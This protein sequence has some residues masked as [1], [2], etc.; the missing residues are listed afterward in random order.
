MATIVVRTQSVRG[1][2]TFTNET[3]YTQDKLQSFDNVPVPNGQTVQIDLQ[4]DVSELKTL[5]ISSDAAVTFKTNST[6]S[7]AATVAVGAGAPVIW[8]AYSGQTNP[9]GSTDVTT[10]YITNASGAAATVNLRFLS[11]GTP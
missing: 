8:P 5:V 2:E 10:A 1:G 3:T 6:G 11:D 4:I 9:L 7:P